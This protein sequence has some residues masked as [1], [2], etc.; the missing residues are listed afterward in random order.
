MNHNDLIHEFGRKSVVE[1]LHIIE[2][3]CEKMNYQVMMAFMGN[4][5]L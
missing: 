4:S 5:N 3:F 1:H 2:T